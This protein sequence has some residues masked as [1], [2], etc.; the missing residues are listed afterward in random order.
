M[1]LV[2]A[3]AVMVADH[4]SPWGRTW[5]SAGEDDDRDRD[6]RARTARKGAA[7]R[8]MARRVRRLVG[9]DNRVFICY[10]SGSWYGRSG[11]FRMEISATGRLGRRQR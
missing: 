11:F 8:A 2:T 9:S 5:A 10:A 7:K 4:S 6:S 3:T 1:P